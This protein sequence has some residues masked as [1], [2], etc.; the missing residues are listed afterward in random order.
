MQQKYSQYPQRNSLLLNQHPIIPR[1]LHI[2]I[3]YEGKLEIRPEAACFA[4][5][6]SPGEVGVFR[7]GGDA[8][9]VGCEMMRR[10]EDKV[11]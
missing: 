1:D 8:Y 6:C 4:F 11:K 3:G 10:E 2:S 5:L 7:V 9:F